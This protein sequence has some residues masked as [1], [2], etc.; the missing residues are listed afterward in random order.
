MKLT[1]ME[2][3]IPQK[4]VMIG[5][6]KITIKQYITTKEKI[7]IID[8]L[9][10]TCLNIEII[11][12]VKLDALFNAYIILNYTDIEFESREIED[13]FQLYDYFEVNHFMDIIITNIPK[14]EIDALIGYL[15]ETIN[16]FDKVKLSLLAAIES[17]IATAPALME[18]IKN[19]S[20]DI[21]I[22]SLKVLGKISSEYK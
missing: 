11:D 19:I 4:E 6:D 20:K 21:D 3:Q 12:R 13:L 18:E 10:S 1:N 9:K 17:L 2:I 8:A 15:Q 22:D 14:V 7:D 5:P 16:D